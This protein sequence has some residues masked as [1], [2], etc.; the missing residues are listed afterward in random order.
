LRA[1][2]FSCSIK[3]LYPD[4]DPLEMLDPDPESGSGMN[5][6]PKHCRKYDIGIKEG[7]G[8]WCG[9]IKNRCSC[10]TGY[11]EP[12]ICRIETTDAE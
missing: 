1:E 3:T 9:G 7:A 6:D 11:Y 8:D 10:G 2:G 12:H 4:Q 5:P